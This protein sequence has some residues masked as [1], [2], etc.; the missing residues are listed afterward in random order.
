MLISEPQ[1]YRSIDGRPIAVV[2]TEPTVRT[3]LTD[4]LAND[5]HEHDDV[6]APCI[7][8]DD[9]NA[10]DSALTWCA[11]PGA[12][13]V[14]FDVDRNA[15]AVTANAVVVCED[16]IAGHLDPMTA[17]ALFA[18]NE[19][20]DLDY[21]RPAFPV[22]A[23]FQMGDVTADVDVTD[24]VSTLNVDNLSVN[25][26]LDGHFQ[27]TLVKAVCRYDL[28]PPM[29]ADPNALEMTSISMD[30]YRALTTS[31]HMMNDYQRA[32]TRTN[33]LMRILTQVH[34]LCHWRKATAQSSCDT[35][36]SILVDELSVDHED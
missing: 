35:A 34:D 14:I 24:V 36:I 5:G 28:V 16:G 29:M 15:A 11:L 4:I 17:D 1:P 19:A 33:A 23:T 8:I 32:D 27:R 7:M 9:S 21:R 18:I 2:P 22:I 26:I 3:R 13:T 31:L 25:P 30:I 20:C 12:Q 10:L 6:I